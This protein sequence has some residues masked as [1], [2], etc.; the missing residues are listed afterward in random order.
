MLLKRYLVLLLVLAFLTLNTDTSGSVFKN[1]KK[2]NKLTKKKLEAHLNGI[3]SRIGKR[4][5][6]AAIKEY[7][8][9]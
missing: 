4:T 6:T 5:Q 9:I 8:Y 7:S 2:F 1:K 3:W